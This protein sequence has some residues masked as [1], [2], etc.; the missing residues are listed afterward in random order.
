MDELQQQ[1]EES[2][3]PSLESLS[4][5]RHTDCGVI[6]RSSSTLFGH[7]HTEAKHQ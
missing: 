1:I 7:A 2:E 4:S 5:Q 6:L 3:M